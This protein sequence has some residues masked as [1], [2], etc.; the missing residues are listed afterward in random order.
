MQ[1]KERFFH[2]CPQCGLFIPWLQG[3]CDCGYRFKRR[4]PPDRRIVALI[5]VLSALLLIS[6]GIIARILPESVPVMEA[7]LPTPTVTPSPARSTDSSPVSTPSYSP[8]HI[9]I[10]STAVQTP[11]PQ[12]VLIFN[13][14]IVKDTTLEKLAPLTVEASSGTNYYIFLKC[15]SSFGGGL[16]LPGSGN[17][18]FYVSAGCSTEVY[19]PLGEYEIY[20]ATGST[21]YGP[22]LKFGSDTEYC[23]CEDTFSFYSTPSGYSGW[24][25]KLYPIFNGN[26]ATET[27]GAEEFPE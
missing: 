25:L 12:P 11:A 22:E 24:T 23:K 5:A 2:E 16:V 15:L 7:P 17:M 4:F 1:R 10:P 13:G 3:K 18:S 19:V 9:G 20:Y 8:F 27:V 21:W 26:V 6:V 14:S